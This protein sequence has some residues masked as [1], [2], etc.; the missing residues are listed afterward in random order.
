MANV[1]RWLGAGTIPVT[2]LAAPRTGAARTRAV[3]DRI[4]KKKDGTAAA[5]NTANRKRMVLN[6]AL[7][8]AVETNA[9]P[10]NPLNAVKWTR[11]RRSKPSTRAR[12]STATRHGAA[13]AVRAVAGGERLPGRAVPCPQPAGGADH[14]GPAD[15][16]VADHQRFVPGGRPR[17]DSLVKRPSCHSQVC[18]Y[19]VPVGSR[20]IGPP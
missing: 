14:D 6:N 15:A 8:Y 7:H 20:G 12:W 3:L 2:D 13:A 18:E 4:S 19:R 10:V 9:L 17:R 5:A 1:V 16:G 11:P